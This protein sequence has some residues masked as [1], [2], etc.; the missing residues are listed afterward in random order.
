M[1]ADWELAELYE[2][3]LSCT[4]NESTKSDNAAMI[5]NSYSVSEASLSKN[6]QVSAD[7]SIYTTCIQVCL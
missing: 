7:Q 4:L 5:D 3:I 6:S 2:S 1:D